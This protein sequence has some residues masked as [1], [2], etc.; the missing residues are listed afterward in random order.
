MSPELV[1]QHSRLRVTVTDTVKILSRQGFLLFP[2]VA[3]TFVIIAGGL[4]TEFGLPNLFRDLPGEFDRPPGLYTLFRSVSCQTQVFATALMGLIWTVFLLINQYENDKDA[5]RP[6]DSVVSVLWPGVV[7]LSGVQLLAAQMSLST[8]LPAATLQTFLNGLCGSLI[9]LI[10]VGLAVKASMLLADRVRYSHLFLICS[11]SAAILSIS[12]SFSWLMPGSAIFIAQAWFILAYVCLARTPPVWRFPLMLGALAL[13]LIGHL[14]TQKLFLPGLEGAANP[15][16][17]NRDA[18]SA[19]PSQLLSPVAVLE[20]WRARVGQRNGA[21]KPKFVVVAASGGA[22]RATYW[23]AKVLDHLTAQEDKGLPGITDSIRLFTGASGGMVGAAYFVATRSDTARNP[24]VEAIIDGDLSSQAPEGSFNG[25]FRNARRD[26]LATVVVTAIQCDFWSLFWP[27]S[28]HFY[29][30]TR[31]G[32]AVG[33]GARYDRGIALERQWRR[34]DDDTYGTFASLGAAEAEG[35]RPSIILS[36]VLVPS[37]RPLLISNLDL[38]ELSAATPDS[39]E[40]FRH[41]PDTRRTLRLSTAVRMNATFPY[42]SPAGQIPVPTLDHQVRR[43]RVVDAGYRDNDG[44]AVAT[45]FLTSKSVKQWLD[46]NTSGVV[47]IQINAF[48]SLQTPSCARSPIASTAPGS[49]FPWL[50]SALTWLTTPLEGIVASRVATGSFANRQQIKLL[51]T[52]FPNNVFTHIEFSDSRDGGF[53]WFQPQSDILRM[54]EEL[55]S[56]HNSECLDKLKSAWG[57]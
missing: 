34:I 16:R 23:T 20:K 4:G 37:G 45:A 13:L 15:V 40:L 54:G 56:A 2:V 50:A 30:C 51:E 42:I 43:E 27:F 49:A 19:S 33:V 55:T 9:G 10:V 31:D 52:I 39:V 21:A 6:I 25:T 38:S 8:G 5:E 41:M 46:E 1:P 47:L 32:K 11:I 28:L 48:A 14:P 18:L 12:A 35:L 24:G 44:I 17:I 22:Y 7:V 36:P 53:N 26:S 57:R 3:G 29:P